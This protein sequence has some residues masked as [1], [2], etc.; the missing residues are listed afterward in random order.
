MSMTIS[1]RLALWIAIAMIAGAAVIIFIAYFV[2][3]PRVS[4]DRQAAY[5]WARASYVES[6]PSSFAA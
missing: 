3:T 4:W 2:V 1:G 6:S 5:P